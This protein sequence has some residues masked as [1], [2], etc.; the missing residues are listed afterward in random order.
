MGI[1]FL[2]EL[3]SEYYEIR[4]FL[5]RRNVP[6][7]KGLKRGDSNEIDLLAL[8]PKNQ[9]LLHVETDSVGRLKDHLPKKFRFNKADYEKILGVTLSREPR[10]I[11]IS[12]AGRGDKKK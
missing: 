7:G 10:R 2:E 5:I 3:A 9:E 11:A 6:T 4:G 1:N 12:G 8:C